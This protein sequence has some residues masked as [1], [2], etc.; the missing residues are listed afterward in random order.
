[1]NSDDY[2]R[3]QKARDAEY[4]REYRA[5]IQSLPADERRKLEAQGLAEPSVAQTLTAE[6]LRTASDRATCIAAANCSPAPL[7][8]LALISCCMAGRAMTAMIPMM[9]TVTISSIIVKP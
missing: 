1:M 4:E 7:S 8:R 3:K 6:F 2:T 5:W 9:D